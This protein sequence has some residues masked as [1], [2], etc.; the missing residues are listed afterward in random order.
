MLNWISSLGFLCRGCL[1]PSPLLLFPLCKTCGESL[2]VCPNLCSFCASPDCVQFSHCL[3]PWS[4][5]P[6]SIQSFDSLY[7]LVAN[8][9]SVLRNWKKRRGWLLDRLI[10]KKNSE[11]LSRW[12]KIQADLLIPIPQ[13]NQRSWNLRGSPVEV[14]SRWISKHT[15]V[16]IYKGLVVIPST[17][18]PQGTLS[19]VERLQTQGLYQAKSKV[20][21][22]SKTI[23][24]VD[25]FYTTG[26]TIQN[27][28]K[29][30]ERA[31]AQKI[32][33]ICLGRRP[34]I[35]RQKSHLLKRA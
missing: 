8:G 14:F 29:A 15:N 6:N 28:A 20:D 24:L 35:R 34:Q 33:V 1:Q 7:L 12:K 11:K 21:L 30:L 26:T 31:G 27:A 32:H 2:R 25:D 10:L 9:Y 5:K 13:Q 23:L 4:S 19:L 17:Q 22:K 16:P 18:K 3:R